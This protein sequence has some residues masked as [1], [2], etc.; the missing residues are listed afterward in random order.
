[1]VTFGVSYPNDFRAE[2]TRIFRYRGRGGER[3]TGNFQRNLRR[4]PQSPMHCNQCSAGRDVQGS[5]KLEEVF[6][7]LVT[8]ANKHGDCERQPYPFAAFQF[9]LTTIQSPSPFL[10]DDLTTA[11]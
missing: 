1:M 8:T 2:I 11:P 7:V 6:P 9:R 10:Q 4:W 5:G 3:R